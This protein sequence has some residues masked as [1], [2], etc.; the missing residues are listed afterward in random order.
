MAA[1]RDLEVFS[2]VFNV[3]WSKLFTEFYHR[4]VRLFTWFLKKERRYKS[5]AL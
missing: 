5:E 1:V 2:V 3:D 4:N